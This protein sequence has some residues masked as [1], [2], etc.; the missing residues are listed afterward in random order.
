MTIEKTKTLKVNN[1]GKKLLVNQCQQIRI[2]NLLK[3][4]KV[5]LKKTFINSRVETAGVKVKFTT[6]K[7]QNNGRRLWFECPICKARIGILYKHPLDNKI[8][9]RRCLNLD[10]KSHRYKG[11]IEEKV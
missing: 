10:Y 8:G 5:K 2:N 4:Y 1:Y 3:K 11:M 6:S 7:T 9:C